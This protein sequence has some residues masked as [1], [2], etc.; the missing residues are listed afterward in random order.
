MI[1]TNNAAL[2]DAYAADYDAQVQ[3]YDC[4]VAEVLFGLCYDAVRPGQ[5][6]LD[7]G[8]GSGLSAELFAK[9]GLEVW[10][11]DFAPAMLELCRAKGFATDLRQHDLVETPWPYEAGS[12]DHLVCCGVMHFIPD[13]EGIFTEAARLLVAGGTLAFTTRLPA[14][15]LE[16][17][18]KYDWQEV[19]D[20]EIFSHSP[21]YIA[22][23]LAGN[24]FAR[25]KTQR[26]F[27]GEDV[28]T[29]WVAQRAYAP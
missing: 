4:H 1:Q 29:L 14:A 20:F 9:A 5:R 6:L 25:R 23:L 18:Q 26:C 2:H 24:G 7:A 16:A 12:F 15:P 3:A 28:F 19:G 10:G 22:G 11:M 27:V 21:A 13:L 17:K 8:T